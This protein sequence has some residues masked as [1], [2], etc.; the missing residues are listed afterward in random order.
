[1]KIIGTISSSLFPTSYDY[2]LITAKYF[3]ILFFQFFVLA[4]ALA[5]ILF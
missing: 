4:I 3:Y 1:M 2:L 5:K